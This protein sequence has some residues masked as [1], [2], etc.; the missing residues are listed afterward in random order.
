MQ[1][2]ISDCEYLFLECDTCND[3]QRIAKNKGSYWKEFNSF[4]KPQSEEHSI[5][6]FLQHH[7]ECPVQGIRIR[8]IT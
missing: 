8:W 4:T 2:R 1:H 7:S 3:T 5:I 6:E